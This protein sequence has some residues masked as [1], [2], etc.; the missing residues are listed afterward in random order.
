MQTQAL[1]DLNLRPK[2]NKKQTLP[3]YNSR[4]TVISDD[5]PSGCSSPE[6]SGISSQQTLPLSPLPAK[7]PT[8]ALN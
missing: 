5:N 4:F 8:T 2:Y 1:P 6:S 7:K 3:Q